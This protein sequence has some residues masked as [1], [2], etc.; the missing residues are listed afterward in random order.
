M[1][2]ALA[3]GASDRKVMEVR[4]LSRPPT[5]NATTLFPSQSTLYVPIVNVEPA[6]GT[7]DQPFGG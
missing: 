1:A 2:D 4:L 6:V 5:V 7:G 3:S